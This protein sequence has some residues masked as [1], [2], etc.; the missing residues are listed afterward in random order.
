MMTYCKVFTAAD[1]DNASFQLEHFVLY[2]LTWLER[3]WTVW[4]KKVTLGSS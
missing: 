1:I 2:L 3:T 4:N